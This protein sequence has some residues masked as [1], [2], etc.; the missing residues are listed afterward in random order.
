MRTDMKIKCTYIVEEVLMNIWYYFVR[1]EKRN[2]FQGKLLKLISINEIHVRL[3]A[4]QYK[5][6]K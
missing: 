2:V 4:L 6:I 3:W 5:I 1:C